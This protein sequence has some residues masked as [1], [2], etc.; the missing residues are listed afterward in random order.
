MMISIVYL[1]ILSL[2]VNCAKSVPSIIFIMADDLGYGDV[3][4]YSNP[5]KRRRLLTPNLDK[6]AS[7][8]MRFTDAYAGFSVCAPSR[9]A[10]MTGYHSGHGEI[11][12]KEKDTTV[13]KMLSE[14]AGYSTYLLGKW[15]LD[16]NFRVPQPPNAGFPTK[17]G[18][19]HFFGQSDQWQCHNYYPAWMFNKTVN[20]TI[21]AN[22]HATKNTCGKDYKECVWSADLWTDAAIK[23]INAQ[24]PPSTGAKPFFMYLSYTSPHAGSVGSI[25]ENDVPAPRTSTGPYANETGWPSVEIDFATAVTATDTAIG[26][27]LDALDAVPGLATETIV[28]FSSD[29][30]AHNEG[31]HNH[32]FFNSSGYLRGFKRSIHD[33]GHRAALI[34]RWTDHIAPNSISHQQW[35]FYDFMLTAAELGGVGYPSTILPGT[36]HLDGYSLVPTLLGGDGAQPQ[37]IFI[38]HEYPGA[39]DCSHPDLKNLSCAFGQNIRMG[40]WSVVCVGPNKPCTGKGSNSKAFLYDM[41]T[42]QSQLH[43]VA[44]KHPDIVANGLTIMEQQFNHNWPPTHNFKTPPCGNPNGQW[45]GHRDHIYNLTYDKDSGI[46]QLAVTDNCCKWATAK[47]IYKQGDINKFIVNA[48]GPS[49]FTITNQ[50]GTISNR[51]C[52][53]TWNEHG[54]ADW[55]MLAQ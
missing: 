19:D 35:C 12:L 42:D 29:N 51:G 54:W 13:A 5:T 49:H 22:E 28:F 4:V 34:V 3:G 36:L 2:S 53:I 55:D 41:A 14:G 23:I 31:G 33:G 45:W 15:G 25:A 8:G 43:D 50:T 7:E 47:G 21:D 40:N 46:V 18:F 11:P 6:M 52:H 44:S 27:V 1:L 16:G 17:Q 37:P 10:L 39:N 32:F 9:H 30:G 48:T 38:Y 26:K 20:I 24:K